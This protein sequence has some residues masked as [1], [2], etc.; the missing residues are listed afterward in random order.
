MENKE[1]TEVI[2]KSL[3]EWKE[4]SGHQIPVALHI[5]APTAISKTAISIAI[6]KI[7]VLQYA[8]KYHNADNFYKPVSRMV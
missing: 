4:S 1:E 2:L 3:K 7:P 5:T 8:V 6:K